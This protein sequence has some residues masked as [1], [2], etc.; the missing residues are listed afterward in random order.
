MYTG[1]TPQPSNWSS[2]HV[3]EYWFRLVSLKSLATL[4]V[5]FSALFVAHVNKRAYSQG[6]IQP[7]DVVLDKAG[8]SR[9]K[10]VFDSTGWTITTY[11]GNGRHQ[12]DDY[13][14]LDIARAC[15]QTAGQNLYAGI[16]GKVYMRDY[17]DGVAYGKSLVVY[18][19]LS[20]FVLR[21]GH[22]KEFASN[23]SDGM[24][25]NAGDYV[26]KVGNSGQHAPTQC[27]TDPGAHLHLA[28]YKNVTSVSSGNPVF[29]T[30]TSGPAT[31]YAAEFCYF[32][33]CPV[34]PA[35]TNLRATPT[36]STQITVAWDYPHYADGFALE[37]S[38]GTGGTFSWI[39]N[40]GMNELTYTNSNL[41]GTNTYCYRV[42]TY[43]GIKDSL[44]SNVG[45]TKPSATSPTP[46]PTPSPG[47]SPTPT[48]TPTASPS[49]T[50]GSAPYNV[51]ATA[52]SS[53][54]V[55]ITWQYLWPSLL[56][57]PPDRI[58]VERR[59]EPNGDWTYVG[60]NAHNST[61][62]VDSHVTSGTTYRYRA[63]AAWGDLVS[64]LR[65]SG[66]GESNAVTTPSC[67]YQL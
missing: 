61:Q 54:R 15:G 16:S 52:L 13:Y 67:R 60:F 36:S 43:R 33:Y 27:T 38:I 29:Q 47:S 63:R 64:E 9:I 34:P 12:G 25:V 65:Y 24:N 7:P 42:K 55:Q 2:P 53:T 41:I 28:L 35:P 5:I 59:L 26:G 48:P 6:G 19:S 23:L 44:Y 4:L 3:R 18:D 37:R 22:M 46:T 1:K 11:P 56:N 10:D 66:Y 62:L 57:D 39:A 30:D 14:A 50:P 58:E 17:G 8:A 31:T 49:P 32:D 51:I 40:L 20:G 45:C 21:Y